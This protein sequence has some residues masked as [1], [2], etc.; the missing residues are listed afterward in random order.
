MNRRIYKLL[1]FCMVSM[2]SVFVH[3]ADEFIAILYVDQDYGGSSISLG[4]GNYTQDELAKYGISAKN[5]SSLKVTKGFKIT[6]YENA[7][8]TGNS[9]SWTTDA[10]FVGD[11]WN[12]KACSVQIE[13]NGKSGLSGN[14]NI[15]NRNSGK[16]LD[17]TDNKTDNNTPI[18]SLMTR[19]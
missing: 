3:A 19:V 13:P 2:L 9:K 8:L 4:E 17:L 15:M 7:D 18:A 16:Y 14:F 11:D 12:D 6:L 1:L 5:I 10:S